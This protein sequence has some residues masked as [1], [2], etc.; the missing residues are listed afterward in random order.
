MRKYTSRTYPYLLIKY[1]YNIF[2]SL[3]LDPKINIANSVIP[4]I[5]QA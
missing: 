5:N 3:A 1:P 4:R 2:T